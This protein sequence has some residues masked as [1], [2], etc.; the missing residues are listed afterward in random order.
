MEALAI[1]KDIGSLSGYGII[2]LIVYILYRDGVIKFGKNGKNGS[3]K[4]DVY[5]TLSAIK[6]NH[7]HE[8]KDGQNAILNKLDKLQNTLEILEKYGVKIRKE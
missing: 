1:A 2:G 3:G 6:D 5:S 7:L 4:P 8:L